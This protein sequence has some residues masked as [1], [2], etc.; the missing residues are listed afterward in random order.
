MSIRRVRLRARG[1]AAPGAFAA[2]LLIAAAPALAEAPADSAVAPDALPVAAI[3][4]DSA[5]VVDSASTDS[6]AALAEPLAAAA[7]SA[8]APAVDALSLADCLELANRNNLGYLL[9]RA[10]LAATEE[11][12]RQARSPFSPNVNASL[13]VPS[14]S[15]R[16]TVIDNEA[17]LTRVRQ[18]DTNFDYEG[19][20]S[21][22]QRVRHLGQF[23]VSGNTQRS[24]FTS[25]RRQDFREY[26]TDVS[27]GYQQ[28]IFTEPEA[29][30]SLRQAELNLA[31]GE[32]AFDRQRVQL[33]TQVTNA[34][35][36]LV[37]GIRQL[38]IQKQRLEQSASA[39]ELAQRKF[40]I[41][42]IAEVEALRLEV[43]KLRAEAEYAAAATAIESRRDAL[44]QVLAMDMAAP[45]EVST[46]VS[47]EIHQID[48]ASAVAVGLSRRSDMEQQR[49]RSR[50]NELALE[51]TKNRVGPT[52]TLNAR[53]TLT[54]RGPAPEDVGSTLERSLVSAS[55]DVGL[56]LVDGG[57]RRGQVR[58]AELALEQG[59]LSLEQTRQTVIREIREAVRSVQDAERQIQ[60]L[61]AALD[62]AERT[63]AVENSRF[64]L[65]L[66]D[67]QQLLDAQTDLTQARTSALTAVVSYQRALQDLRLATMAQPQELVAA[68]D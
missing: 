61:Q 38:A 26:L 24:D 31:S 14:Y 13:T 2:A 42:L 64:E 29:E 65:G 15:E 25:N 40:E 10:A 54:G 67:S 47:Y 5:G 36:N 37:Q 1:H 49:I 45:L 19:M 16:R 59:Q 22:S 11:R 44:R 41:G 23:T 55:I 34:Y 39:L 3:T 17:L 46:D 32:H 62:V 52:A 66:A 43:D 18:E 7:D 28:E 51:L 27:L 30:L 33:E 6:A 12:L 4:Q 56:P 48:A 58:Q 20:L 63:F 68:G 50:V 9:D 21:L 57:Q 35:Y 8:S 53:L 60:L